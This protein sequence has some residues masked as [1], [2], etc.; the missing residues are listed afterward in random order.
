MTKRYLK[1][2]EVV[3][4]RGYTSRTLT[5]QIEQIRVISG[6]DLPNEEY[7]FFGCP[8]ESAFYKI[9]FGPCFF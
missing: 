7:R 6:W 1:T 4:H 8:N 3:F 9:K 2:P 5:R